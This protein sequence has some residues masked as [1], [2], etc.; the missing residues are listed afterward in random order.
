MD[1]R[2]T[3][4]IPHG[5]PGLSL[6]KV[7]VGTAERIASTVAG[8]ALLGLAMTTRRQRTPLA[9]ASAP[10][11]FRGITGHCTLYQVLGVNTAK[12]TDATSVAYARGFRVV[13]SVTIARPADELYAFWRDFA[14]LPRFMRHLESVTPIDAMRS[15]WVAKGPAG[16]RVEWDAEIVNETGNSLIGWRSLDNSD[17]DHAGSVHFEPLGDRGTTVKVILRYDPPAG[18]VG[19]AF[20]KLFREEPSQQ[21]A[22]DLR[23]FKQLM[24]TGEIATTEGQPAGGFLGEE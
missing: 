7:N 24:E 2:A 16:L 12:E 13:K 18:A 23:R 19:M 11:L 6:L 20:A 8:A 21:I 14:N 3:G 17:V 22:D 1:A 4:E 10:L 15:R 5:T 9:V